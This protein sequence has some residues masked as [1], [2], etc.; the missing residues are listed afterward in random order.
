LQFFLE[1][2]YEETWNYLSDFA[3]VSYARRKRLA[4]VV[5]LLEAKRKEIN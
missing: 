4:K 1:E 2:C 5:D 3:Q